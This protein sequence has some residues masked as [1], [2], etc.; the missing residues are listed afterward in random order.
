M[1]ILMTVLLVFAKAA[2]TS[3][4]AFRI[5][6]IVF[7]WFSLLLTMATALS[8]FSA[9]VL[10]KPQALRDLIV[11]T[12]TSQNAPDKKP[13]EVQPEQDKS[14]VSDRIPSVDPNDAATKPQ[15]KIADKNAQL[16]APPSDQAPLARSELEIEVLTTEHKGDDLLRQLI[17]DQ[18]QFDSIGIRSLDQMNMNAHQVKYILDTVRGW[19]NKAAALQIQ[20]TALGKRLL[21][22][23][24]A[25]EFKCHEQDPCEAV[26]MGNS[27]YFLRGEVH[28][29]SLEMALQTK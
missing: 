9:V 15:V 8:L 5:P 28:T 21:D 18:E 22:K 16:S 29:T 12:A 14:S 17:L 24:N 11:S 2:G 13:N 7:T 26:R 25:T 19:W 23:N 27:F 6:L 4:S 3:G 1:F 20:P 10:G